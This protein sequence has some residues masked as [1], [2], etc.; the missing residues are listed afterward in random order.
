M[1]ARVHALAALT[2]HLDDGTQE[3]SNNAAERSIYLFAGS[4]ARGQRAA[5]NARATPSLRPSIPGAFSS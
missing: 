2:R 5:G 1:P 4:D 3:I